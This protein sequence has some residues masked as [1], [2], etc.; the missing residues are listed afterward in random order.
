MMQDSSRSPTRPRAT[1]S[2]RHFL[3]L[4][5]AAAAVLALPKA[6]IPKIAAALEASPRLPVVWLECQDCTGD[7]ESFLRAA[8][9][10]NAADGNLTDPS[11]VDLL[12]DHIS[13]E[14]HETLMAPAGASAEQSRADVLSHYA[15]QFLCVV[16]GSI[17]TALNGAYCTVGGRTA[18]S[19][20]REVT[21]QARATVALGNCAVDGGLAAA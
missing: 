6:E 20:V 2:R 1:L 19:I 15:G 3:E 10:R 4:C 16:E 12:L 13:V 17:P 18:L 5:G 21:A 7:S 9:R 8:Q 11:L 14:Y